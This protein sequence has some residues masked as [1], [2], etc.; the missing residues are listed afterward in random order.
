MGQCFLGFT[1]NYVTTNDIELYKGQN[2]SHYTPEQ[3]EELTTTLI[4]FDSGP[5]YK[6]EET[7]NDLISRGEINLEDDWSWMDI[8]KWAGVGLGIL[9]GIMILYLTIQCYCVQ[10]RRVFSMI[11]IGIPGFPLGHAYSPKVA[12]NP[13]LSQKQKRSMGKPVDTYPNKKNKDTTDATVTLDGGIIHYAVP[14]LEPT[15]L[16]RPILVFC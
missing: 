12:P 16:E 8:L 1:E 2:F 3:I 7:F 6:L 10:T 11:P 5:M 13:S 4:D 9:I 15:T 14:Q